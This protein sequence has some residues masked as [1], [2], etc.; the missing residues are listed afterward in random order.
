[1]ARGATKTAENQPNRIFQQGQRATGTE[2]AIQ[3]Q[4]YGALMPQITSMLQPGGNPAVTA[5][6]M[7]AL[8]SKFGDAKQQALDTATR[9]NNAA[10]TNAT[11]DQLARSQ[12]SAGAQAAAN[13]VAGQ[14]K[15]ATGLLAQI[16]GQ[17]NAGVPATLN[18]QTGAN[19]SY[20]KGIKSGG[21]VL[22]TILRSRRPQR[23]GAGG[24][25]RAGGP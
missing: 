14:Q 11:I 7:G 13:N 15:T 21:G 6:T 4:T 1:M 10:S 12:G 23:C 20:I 24:R 8:G 3:G 22:S 17:A 18:A 2:Q 16:F 19:N 5:A 9:T 25:R